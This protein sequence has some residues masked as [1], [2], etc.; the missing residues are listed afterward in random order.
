MNKPRP[1]KVN[2]KKLKKA[3]S[4]INPMTQ[5]KSRFEIFEEMRKKEEIPKTYI[6]LEAFCALYGGRLEGYTDDE[7]RKSWP[8]DWGSETLTVPA[9]LVQALTSAWVDY[10]KAPSGKTLGEAFKLEGGGQGKQKIKDSIKTIFKNRQLNNEVILNY[11]SVDEKGQ[12]ISVDQAISN[13]STEKNVSEETGISQS[14]I[15]KSLINRTGE[16]YDLGHR[17]RVNIGAHNKSEYSLLDSF[18]SADGVND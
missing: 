1:P 12:S 15:R 18:V 7:I 4:Q 17:W 14:K 2:E 5:L 16:M 9:V 11:L 8:K 3:K 10:Q 6:A 13:V